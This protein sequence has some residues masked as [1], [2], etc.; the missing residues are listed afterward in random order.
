MAISTPIRI[1]IWIYAC[2]DIV[3]LSR[4][5]EYLTS[6]AHILYSSD[7][8][9]DI[10]GYTPDEI[11]NRS[12][13]DFFPPEEVPFAKRFHE[14]RVSMDKAAVLAY[15]RVR[16]RNGAWVGCECCF[17]VVYDV[18]V[19]CTS[20][21]KRSSSSQGRALAAPVVR[22]MFSSSPRDPRYHMLSHLSDKFSQ[23]YKH[24]EH[25]PRA[26]LFLNRFT[27][28]LTI[29]YATSGLDDII[30]VPAA[31]IRGRSFYH[32]IAENCLQD[33]VKCLENAKGNDSVAYLRFW[34]RDPR[35]DDPIQHDDDDDDDDGDEE[36]TDAATTEMSE[37]L[38][39]GGVG[40]RQ[41]DGTMSSQYSTYSNA[42]QSTNSMDANEEKEP[43]S[44]T[45]SDE[46]TY[47]TDTHEGIFGTSRAAESSASSLAP[48]PAERRPYPLISHDPIELEAV[49]SCTSDGLVVCLRRAR[50]MIPHPT[51]RPS[52]PAYPRGL[53]AAPWAA[54]PMLPPI[55]QRPAVGYGGTFAPS[56]GPQG[57][58][59]DSI[60]PVRTGGPSSQDFMNAIR[61]QAIF[62]W[63]L[64]GINGAVADFAK[65]KPTGASVP[66]DGLPIWASDP[67]SGM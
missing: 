55:D 39:E 45:S 27:R 7:S 58:R 34:F 59:H 22:R 32:C 41:V 13:W 20:I 5:I 54:E 10:L 64:T 49:I 43:N 25:E 62:A 6:G 1:D 17:T 46:S 4:R 47:M 63:A 3:M 2:R 51:A 37:D 61:D 66:Q 30:G 12:A 56:L 35:E 18:M 44:R 38:D 52:Q 14:K 65:G 36:M 24:N 42:A 28:T 53:F 11:V 23:D 57:A 26:A 48:S 33:A 15:C 16:D 9:V 40:L 50:P 19:V 67:R 31:H 29:M 21:Y 60:S 8:V